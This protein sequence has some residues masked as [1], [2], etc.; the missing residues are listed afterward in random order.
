MRSI[1]AREE[2][3]NAVSLAE[4]NAEINR[5]NTTA[6]TVSQSTTLIA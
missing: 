6:N 4:K 1:A 3:A 2:A 5:H